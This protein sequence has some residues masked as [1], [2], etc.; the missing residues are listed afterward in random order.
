MKIGKNN[1]DEEVIFQKIT[2]A[3]A[4]H[5]PTTDEDAVQGYIHRFKF[6]KVRFAIH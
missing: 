4:T 2:L 5:Q 3:G 6:D 1:T